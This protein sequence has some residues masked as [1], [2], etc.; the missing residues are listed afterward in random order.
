VPALQS[1]QE[2]IEEPPVA[3]LNVPA[4]QAEVLVDDCGQYE[5]GGHSSGANKPGV[6]HRVPAGQG[7]QDG[8]PM[9]LKDPAGHASQTETEVAPIWPENVPPAHGA[10]VELNSAPTEALYVP[11]AQGEQN[12]APTPLLNEPAAQEVGFCEPIE[13]KA[14]LGQIIGTPLLQ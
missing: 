1:E 8:A 4:G 10:Q 2:E 11:A 12:D 13:Q 7:E 5:P 3:F 14:P 9:P 6:G